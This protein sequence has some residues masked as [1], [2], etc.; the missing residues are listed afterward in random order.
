MAISIP[1]GIGQPLF[2]LIKMIDRQKQDV[3]PKAPVILFHTLA[4]DLPDAAKY[5]NGM[6]F[7]D[8]HDAPAISNGTVWRLFTMGSTL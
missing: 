1:K 2:D 5:R 7:V 4:A 3:V 8:D 6:V